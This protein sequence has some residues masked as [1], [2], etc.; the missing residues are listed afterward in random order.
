MEKVILKVITAL[1]VVLFSVSLFAIQVGDVL[2]NA[3]IKNTSG[4]DEG[5]PFLGQKVLVIQ[6][7]DV[8]VKDITDPVSNAL[9]AK[10]YSQA[11]YLGIG[12]ANCKDAPLKPDRFITSAAAKKQQAFPNSRIMLDYNRILQGAWG[13]GNC[14]EQG[15]IIV[16]GKDSK[17][18]FF[19]KVKSQQE[20]SA[21]V[22][23]VLS[24]VD[25][26]TAKVK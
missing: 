25:A 15:V 1:V 16:V 21:L 8:D 4:G 23:Q 7:N 24:V 6:Y 22:G 18:K 20:S 10:N 26:E 5:I 19:A 14:N 17:V 12:V 3:T 2:S 9:K 11:K 13:L